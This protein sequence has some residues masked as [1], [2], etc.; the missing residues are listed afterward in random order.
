MNSSSLTGKRVVITRPI[1]QSQDW[2]S[3][4]QK[5]GATSK[6]I[7]LIRIDQ[8]DDEGFAFEQAMRN[9]D[10]YSWIICTSANGASRVAPYLPKQSSPI[11]LAAVGSSTAKAFGRDVAFVPQASSGRALAH[12]FP[13]T[14]G[15]ALLVQAQ[16]ASGDVEQILRERGIDVDVVAAYQTKQC[17]ITSEQINEIQHSDAVIFASGSAIR[18]WAAQSNAHVDGL[19]VVIGESTLQIA[20]ECGLAVQAVASN[21]NADGIAAALVSA[22]A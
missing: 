2:E 20:H 19:V 5:A 15:K 14:D 13:Y 17:N 18:S 21:A 10:K 11:Q 3:A 9:L 7:P 8:P 6:T 16:E 22:F 1:A 4:L 12:E